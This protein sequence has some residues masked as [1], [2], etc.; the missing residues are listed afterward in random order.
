MKS[1]RFNLGNVS[2]IAALVCV[3]AVLLCLSG[4][5]DDRA[6]QGASVLNAKTQLFAKQIKA[7][8]N[9]DEKAALA[10]EFIIKA[11]DLADA[12]DAYINDRQPGASTQPATTSPGTVSTNLVPAPATTV[13]Q[14]APNAPIPAK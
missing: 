11:P 14:P 3:Y 12:V 7:A 6:K 8:K 1:D 10:D 2:V 5:S 4:C 9:N 13:T